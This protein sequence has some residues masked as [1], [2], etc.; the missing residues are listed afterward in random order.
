MLSQISSREDSD[1]N[2]SVHVNIE[3][4][5]STAVYEYFSAKLSDTISDQVTQSWMFYFGFLFY[6]LSGYAAVNKFS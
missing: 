3:K 6:W 2:I 4:S 1:P 5:S